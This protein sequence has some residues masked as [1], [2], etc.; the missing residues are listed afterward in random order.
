MCVCV[1][2]RMSTTFHHCAIFKR[3]KIVTVFIKPTT[4][5]SRQTGRCRKKPLVPML[6]IALSSPE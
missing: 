5:K 3:S 2:M 4:S 6:A 1:R